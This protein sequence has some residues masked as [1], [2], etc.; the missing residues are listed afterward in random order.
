MR[1]VASDRQSRPERGR[2]GNSPFLTIVYLPFTSIHKPATDQGTSCVIHLPR[3]RSCFSDDPP[4]RQSAR[5][6]ARA[7]NKLACRS[8]IVKPHIRLIASDMQLRAAMARALMAAAY[9][10]EVT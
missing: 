10:V 8:G 4:T 7:P 3:Y 9:G 6:Q 1:S 2:F 5:A